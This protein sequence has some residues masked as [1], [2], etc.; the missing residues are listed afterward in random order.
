MKKS[1]EISKEILEEI[2]DNFDRDISIQEML[3]KAKNKWH[4]G[5]SRL[6]IILKENG[7]H[8]IDTGIS[9]YRKKLR[10]KAKSY[11]ASQLD[12]PEEESLIWLLE[13]ELGKIDAQLIIRGY[14]LIKKNTKLKKLLESEHI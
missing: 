2:L 1:A 12:K 14:A 10:E 3:D 5:K 4:I 11:W 13:P 6:F 9:N 8:R 7:R